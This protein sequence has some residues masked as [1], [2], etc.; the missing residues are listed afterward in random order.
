VERAVSDVPVE[1]AHKTYQFSNEIALPLTL[2]QDCECSG[3]DPTRTRRGKR[4]H[5][6]KR[7]TYVIATRVHSRGMPEPGRILIWEH[8]F[9][10]DRFDL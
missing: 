10:E 8:R 6:P 4:G 5:C 2:Y 7:D 9:A 3:L 1:I